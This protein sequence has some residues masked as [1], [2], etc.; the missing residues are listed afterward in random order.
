[1]NTNPHAYDKLGTAKIT[2]DVLHNAFNIVKNSA[3]QAGTEPATSL[4][5]TTVSAL[6]VK[7]VSEYMR[8]GGGRG[9]GEGIQ[10]ATR[11]VRGE[12]KKLCERR[13]PATLL[14]AIDRAHN[15][16]EEEPLL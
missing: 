11:S 10:E 12:E 1:M 2:L 8:G 14:V 5:P 3:T 13:R 9:G 4:L 16:D 15:S 7:R 6:T